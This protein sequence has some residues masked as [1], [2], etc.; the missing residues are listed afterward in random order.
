MTHWSESQLKQH[1]QNQSMKAIEAQ[2]AVKKSKYRAVK[3]TV[4]DK[5]FDS[6]KEA[7]R[8]SQL[9]TMQRVGLISD[10]K[11]KKADC[12]FL[13]TVN[14]DIVCKYIAD[15]VYTELV[16]TKDANEMCWH[17]NKTIVEDVKGIK[18]AVYRLKKKL[19]KAVHGIE[20]KEV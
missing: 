20:I 6:K 17:K 2:K 8:Y 18:T 1:T 5:V 16:I 4:D 12:T 13:L 7:A 3:T 14:G 9:E 11:Y 15:F 10:L 19:M